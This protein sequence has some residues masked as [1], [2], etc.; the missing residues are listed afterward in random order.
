MRVIRIDDGDHATVAVLFRPKLFQP[1]HPAGGEHVQ[2]GATRIICLD[3]RQTQLAPVGEQQRAPVA[4]AGDG[5]RAETGKLASF[6][7]RRAGHQRRC[8]GC[9]HKAGTTDMN[10]TGNRRNWR[11]D[12]MGGA[13]RGS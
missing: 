13:M 7:R 3:C 6:L 11:L 5:R 2:R 10:T 4:H 9:E 12:R 1:Q 8:S